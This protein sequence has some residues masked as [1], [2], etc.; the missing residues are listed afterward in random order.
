MYDIHHA[1]RCIGQSRSTLFIAIEDAEV[2]TII[3]KHIQN[4]PHQFLLDNK[5]VAFS[6]GVDATIIVKAFQY[7]SKL[8]AII[9]DVYPKHC[10]D[11]KYG[12]MAD[13]VK[14]AVA[15]F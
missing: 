4:I 3:G 9:G 12:P 14:V 15:S 1:K 11:D 7:S 2:E 5:W 6:V 10:I 13:E 8:G